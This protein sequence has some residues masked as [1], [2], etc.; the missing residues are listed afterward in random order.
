MSARTASVGEQAGG[1]FVNLSTFRVHYH[2][3]GSGAP[4]VLLHG[5]GPGATGWSNFRSNMAVIARTHRVIAVDMPGWGA[6]DTQTDQTGYDHLRTLLELLDEL[7]I[8]RAALVGNS[9]GGATAVEAAISAPDRVSHLVTMGVPAPGRSYFSAGDGPSEGLKML[10]AAYAE[11]SPENMRRL[12]SIMCYDPRWAT[13]E[14]AGMR[15]EAALRYPEHLESFLR[16]PAPSSY[17]ART[18]EELAS[19][20]APTLVVHGRDDRVVSAENGLRLVSAIPDSRLLLLNRCG[21]WAQLEH[22]EEFNR[23]VVQFVSA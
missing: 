12:V 17:F 3:V 6:S 4:V 9:M 11:P 13:E 16:R 19:I 7:G 22:A 10:R 23:T 21:H 1:R 5:S 18:M 2:D 14:L 20:A 15:S 8:D